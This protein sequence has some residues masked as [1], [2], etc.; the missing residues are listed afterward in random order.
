MDIGGIYYPRPAGREIAYS[1]PP[2][3]P[4]V[5]DHSPYID[6]AKYYTMLMERYGHGFEVIME[7]NRSS[8]HSVNAVRAEGTRCCV[9][10]YYFSPHSPNGAEVSHVTIFSGRPEQPLR[11]LLAAADGHARTLLR[12]VVKRGLAREDLYRGK[13]SGG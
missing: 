6:Q 10:N 2:I 4:T 11:R 9:S 7:T 8:W 1:G 5:F 12:R 3:V 13:D